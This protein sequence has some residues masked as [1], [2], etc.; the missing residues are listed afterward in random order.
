MTKVTLI[1]FLSFCVLGC[2]KKTKQAK[3]EDERDKKQARHE[4]EEFAALHNAV[5]DW[6][7]SISDGI[8]LFQKMWT[9]DVKESL[10]R[11]NGRPIAFT[12]DVEDIDV[13]GGK[14]IVRFYDAPK[15]MMMGLFSGGDIRF[16]LEC[17]KEQIDAIRNHAQEHRTVFSNRFVVVAH[18]ADVHKVRFVISASSTRDPMGAQ[19]EVDSPNVFIARGRCVAVKRLSAPL[20]GLF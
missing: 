4:I 20:G 6:Q 10:V 8:P 14:Y 7:E 19:I 11:P 9:I 17:S 16:D 15:A 18:I 1:I 12:C 5:T 13:L 2:E 3:V